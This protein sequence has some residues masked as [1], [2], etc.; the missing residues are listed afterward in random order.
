MSLKW[1]NP[2][3]PDDI[4]DYS[5]NWTARLDTGDTIAS[6]TFTLVDGEIEL[7][8]TEID[9]GKTIVWISGGVDGETATV[10]NRIVTVGGRQMDLTIQLKV[11][12]R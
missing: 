9:G 10:R 5:V 3:D 6:S 11:K 8:D 7:G 12:T 4:L 1:A 2:K